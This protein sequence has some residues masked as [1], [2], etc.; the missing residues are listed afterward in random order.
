MKMKKI[1]SALV[2]GATAAGL[3]MADVSLAAGFKLGSSAV[4]YNSKDATTNKKDVELFNLN[5]FWAGNSNVAFK[6]TGDIFSFAATLSP[7]VAPL[8]SDIGEDIVLLKIVTI[9]AKLGDFSFLAGWNR[10]GIMRYRATKDAGN[11]EGQVFEAYKPGSMFATDAQCANNQA[12]FQK[13]QTDY[14]AQ[15]G[16]GFA[17]SDNAKLNVMAAVYSPDA[18]GVGKNANTSWDNSLGWGVFVQ[19]VVKNVFEAEVFVKGHGDK[20]DKQ[21]LVIGA[22]GKPTHIPILADSG[23]GGSVVLY[24]GKLTEWN[25]DVRLYFKAND[26]LSFTS[27][28]N[29]SYLKDNSGTKVYGKIGNL[30]TPANIANY[31]LWNMVGMRYRKSNSLHL[32]AT[33]GQQ[34]FFDGDKLTQIFVHPHAQIMASNKVAVTTGIICSVDNLR[35]SGRDANVVVSVPVHLRVDF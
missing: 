25:A 13:D 33:A 8:K 23:I 24:D 20:D 6:A 4:K 11:D 5:N 27:F 15:A 1:I 19:P 3:A 28:N 34:S 14:F 32:V 22:Y 9:G 17:L 35:V 12:G 10:D 21:N 26:K 30:D 29:I 16:Y 2:L 31:A 7:A 18:W